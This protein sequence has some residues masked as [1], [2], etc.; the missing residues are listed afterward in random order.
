MHE[1]NRARKRREMEEARER[2]VQFVVNI[3]LWRRFL[4]LCCAGEKPN[5]IFIRMVEKAV[6]ERESNSTAKA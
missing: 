5:L 3:D 4:V 1:S 2:Y 6:K